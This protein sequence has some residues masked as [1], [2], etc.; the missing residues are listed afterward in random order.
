M[1]AGYSVST[2]ARLVVAAELPA[3]G[4]VCRQ[5]TLRTSITSWRPIER[6]E[7]A[8]RARFAIAQAVIGA[9]RRTVTDG[10]RAGHVSDGSTDWAGAYRGAGRDG[11]QGMYCVPESGYDLGLTSQIWRFRGS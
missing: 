6:R 5:H 11:C 1:P 8:T 3:S 4:S 10:S 9:F 7:A 2:S